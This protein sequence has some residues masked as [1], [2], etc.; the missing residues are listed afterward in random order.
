MTNSQVKNYKGESV[1]WGLG[2]H[3][4]MG[5]SMGSLHLKL[6]AKGPEADF[7]VFM[8]AFSHSQ[9]WLHRY[10]WVTDRPPSHLPLP[11]NWGGPENPQPSVHRLLPW[12]PAP[13]WSASKSHLSRITKDNWSLS[14][15]GP[16]Q[17]FGSWSQ[18][19][20]TGSQIHEKYIGPMN[21]QICISSKSQYH[22]ALFIFLGGTTIGLNSLACQTS[23]KRRQIDYN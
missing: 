4:E 11:R 8:E 10:P 7:R 17:Q 1:L 16:F 14:T 13:F 2:P 19:L 9:D 6:S 20:K 5:G 21:N 3:V 23:R 22:I 15:P 12:Q 18:K